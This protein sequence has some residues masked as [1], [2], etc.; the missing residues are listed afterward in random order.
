MEWTAQ[1]SVR[2]ET[3]GRMKL[4]KPIY[5]QKC[6]CISD[7]WQIFQI[8]FLQLDPNSWAPKYSENRNNMIVTWELFCC[9]GPNHWWAHST[10]FLCLNQWSTLVLCDL[11]GIGR[12]D[13][14]TA[15]V[16]LL[17]SMD[18]F[19][20][21]K[22]E[23]GIDKHHNWNGG[24]VT[25]LSEK[26]D[27]SLGDMNKLNLLW[28]LQNWCPVYISKPVSRPFLFRSCSFKGLGVFTLFYS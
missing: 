1:L 10:N 18:L 27:I 14:S 20:T 23:T 4:F 9:S 13:R 15:P 2:S 19:S 7:L 28:I 17:F 6:W 16:P 12:Y 5:S 26:W 11:D 3:V 8:S 21:Q 24:R 22:G 25:G